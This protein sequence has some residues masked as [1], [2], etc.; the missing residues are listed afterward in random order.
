MPR[1]ELAALGRRAA[2]RVWEARE[3]PLDREEQA[4]LE[5]A[6]PVE[7]PEVRGPAPEVRGPEVAVLPAAPEPQERAAEDRSK[8]GLMLCRKQGR[9]FR[10]MPD[11]TR[12]AGAVAVRVRAARAA[13]QAR[14]AVE[15]ADADNAVFHG[16]GAR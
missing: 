12:A 4:G 2:R 13:R 15:G 16:A 9:M 8:P 14:A 11:R 3:L 7:A 10:S 6:A 1:G 5:K